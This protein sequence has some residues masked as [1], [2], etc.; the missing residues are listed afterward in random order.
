MNIKHGKSFVKISANFISNSTMNRQPYK[1]PFEN[2]KPFLKKF[3]YILFEYQKSLTSSQVWII[4]LIV[5]NIN[6]KYKICFDI[7]KLL[8]YINILVIL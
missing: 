6:A 8:Q 5:V 7:L 3:A 2:V 1:I 4:E